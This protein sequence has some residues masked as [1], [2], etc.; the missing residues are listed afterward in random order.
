MAEPSPETLRLFE[1]FNEEDVSEEQIINYIIDN[2]NRIDINYVRD[3]EGLLELC[4]EYDHTKVMKKLLELGATLRESFIDMLLH[5]YIFSESV[6]EDTKLMD[7]FIHAGLKKEHMLYILCRKISEIHK[8][9]LKKLLEQPLDIN[10]KYEGD[11]ALHRLIIGLNMYNID[12]F[13]DMLRMLMQAG[14]N[15]YEKD[16]D[17]RT[18][19]DLLKTIGYRYSE[20]E[21]TI[22]EILQTVTYTEET[23]NNTAPDYTKLWKKEIQKGNPNIA[24]LEEYKTLGNLNVDMDI[25]T[26]INGLQ[27]HIVRL[28]PILNVIEALLQ[29]G[30]NPNLIKAEKPVYFEIFKHSLSKLKPLLLLFIKYGADLKLISQ[31]K[32][33]IFYFIENIKKDEQIKNKEIEEIVDILVANGADIHFKN[34]KDMDILDKCM[35]LYIFGIELFIKKGLPVFVNGRTR[36]Y[37]TLIVVITNIYYPTLAYITAYIQNIIFMLQITTRYHTNHNDFMR[38]FLDAALLNY[39][40][41]ILPYIF[42]AFNEFLSLQYNELYSDTTDKESLLIKAVKLYGKIPALWVFKMIESFIEGGAALNYVDSL[43][44]KAA[45]YT[46]KEE[47]KDI[48]GEKPFQILWTG[49]SKADIDFTND[50]FHQITHASNLAIANPEESLFSICPVCLKYVQHASGSCMYMTHSCVEQAGY[51]GYYHK[52]LWNAFSYEKGYDALG[53]EIPQGQRKRVLEWCTNCG[54]ICKGHRHYAKSEIYKSGTK[55]IVIPQLLGQGDYFATT[56]DKP[57]IGGGGISEKINR[58]R[59]FR[60]VVLSLNDSDIIGKIP[61]EEAI[62]TLV[63]AVWEAPLDPRRF[64]I[65]RIQKLKKYNISVANDRFPP[66][67]GL[68]KPPKYIYSVPTYPDIANPDLMPLVFSKA[69]NAIKNSAY[70]VFGY[71]ENIVQ[72]RH[73]MADGTINNHDGPNQQIALDRLMGEIKLMT[74]RPNSSDFGFCWQ[75]KRDAYNVDDFLNDK[76]H[77]PKQCTARLYPAEILHVLQ[78]ADYRLDKE[79]N[80]KSN[81]KL[82]LAAKTEHRG[83]YEYYAKLFS[84]KF[85]KPIGLAPPNNTNNANNRNAANRKEPNSNHEGGRRHTV[86]RRRIRRSKTRKY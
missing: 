42:Q 28:N 21:S 1:L 59:R 6:V 47:L 85:G 57:G 27:F 70:N 16:E 14:A 23:P 29:W 61:Y 80:N 72:F 56:C 79:S 22:L 24:K 78:N 50:V 86:K 58:Y 62:N 31:D 11:T 64:E 75:H 15:P 82:D 33:C 36:W 41:N 83:I 34:S 66:P 40:V 37:K 71:D 32:N 48:L 12:I 39:K 25:I 43:G 35:E 5:I 4:L 44:K 8:E 51:E 17:G 3:N 53:A 81:D 2:N 69:T 7:A 73:R 19:F 52:K 54:R 55:E 49:F 46:D 38:D 63:E 20:Y 74:E 18:A 9:L 68:P 13:M 65:D 30:A 26:G 76:S 67:S 60:E 84:E 77:K 10:Y 45:D